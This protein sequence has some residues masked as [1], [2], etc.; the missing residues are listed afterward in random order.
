MRSSPKVLFGLTV[1]VLIAM[2]G[3]A[4]AQ[5]C[6]QPPVGVGKL[7]A[8]GSTDAVTGSREFRLFDLSLRG[9]AGSV[10]Y[11]WGSEIFARFGT[12]SSVSVLRE[13][14]GLMR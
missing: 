13:R 6:P 1:L 11:S 9:R 3:I 14:R 8:A 4:G 5:T 2:A 12:R 10:V 7:Q